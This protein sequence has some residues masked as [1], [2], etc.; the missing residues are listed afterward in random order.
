MGRN[1]CNLL[2]E[3]YSFWH[4]KSAHH[5][6]FQRSGQRCCICQ[7]LLCSACFKQTKTSRC[8]VVPLD[9][10]L[11]ARCRAWNAAYSIQ[12][13]ASVVKDIWL[14]QQQSEAQWALPGVG[15]VHRRAQAPGF[16]SGTAGQ[17]LTSGQDYAM[18]EPSTI[19][20]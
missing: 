8:G 12:Q 18:M 16:E 15:R 2:P 14:K 6:P 20:Y 17:C 1:G 9:I 5:P 13:I 4:K 10:G 19:T 7:F 11:V 3:S